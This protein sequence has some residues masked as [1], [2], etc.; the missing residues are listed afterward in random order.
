MFL[1]HF[2]LIKIHVARQLN[3]SLEYL[4][5]GNDHEFSRTV[6]YAMHNRTLKKLH[7][8]SLLFVNFA[9]HYCYYSFTLF[10]AF[11]ISFNTFSS[12]VVIALVLPLLHILNTTSM[13]ETDTGITSKNDFKGELLLQKHS[14]RSNGILIKSLLSYLALRMLH[15]SVIQF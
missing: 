10:T 12:H 1:T 2:V 6:Q 5:R 14:L 8:L 9:E 15:V 4:M 13:L 3:D 11:L 7:F